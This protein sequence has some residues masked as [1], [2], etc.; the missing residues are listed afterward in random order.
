MVP[1]SLIPTGGRSKYCNRPTTVPP[2]FSVH[3]DVAK[4][5][6]NNSAATLLHHVRLNSSTLQSLREVPLRYHH[7][8]NALP[9]APLIEH[10]IV[11]ADLSIYKTNNHCTPTHQSTKGTTIVFCAT[12]TINLT[13]PPPPPSPN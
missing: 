3:D 13:L 10:I 7:P 11:R 6:S 8:W 4:N 12:V 2:S 5:A 1:T 9:I